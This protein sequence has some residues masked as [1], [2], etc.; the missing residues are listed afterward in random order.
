MTPID[1]LF[2]ELI[3]DLQNKVNEAKVALDSGRPMPEL[4]SLV[5]EYEDARTLF[6]R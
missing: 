3:C 1:Q 6:K 4:K 2:S 5:Q